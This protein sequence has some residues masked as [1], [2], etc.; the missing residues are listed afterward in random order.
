MDQSG[1]LLALARARDPSGTWIDGTIEDFTT[2]ERFAGIVCWDA[3]FH[4][5]RAHHAA[6]LARFARMLESDGRLMLTVGGSA[7]P[8]F[9]D[10]MFGETFFYDSH[11]PG[12]VLSMLRR[13]GFELLVSELMNV[14]TGGRDKGRH[15]I[16]A[17]LPE[18][19]RR[20]GASP[21]D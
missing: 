1:A 18:G 15:A 16:V 19:R 13:E 6:L 2:T 17:R 21:D 3:L 8:A 4:V 11:P 5:A 7:H 20:S 10:M 9:T 14:P 12:E